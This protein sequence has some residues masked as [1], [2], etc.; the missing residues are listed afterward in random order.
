[1]A[2]TSNCGRKNSQKF[3]KFQIFTLKVVKAVGAWIYPLINKEPTSLLSP[4]T[5][6]VSTLRNTVS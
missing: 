4:S 1:M 2:F 6:C 3:K 5:L